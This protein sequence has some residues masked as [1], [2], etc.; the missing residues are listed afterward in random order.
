MLGA[1]YQTRRFGKK[2]HCK[3]R[4]GGSGAKSESINEQKYGSI[5]M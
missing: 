2:G 3:E 4:A 1:D 5:S